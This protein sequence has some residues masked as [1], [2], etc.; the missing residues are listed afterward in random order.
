M[1]RKLIIFS[2]FLFAFCF[3]GCK[4]T[5]EKD[6]TFSLS[7]HWIGIGETTTIQLKK[8]DSL[9]DFS[10]KA[11]PSNYV[12]IGPTGEIVALKK[13]TVQIQ[14]TLKSD[15]TKFYTQ[16]LEISN[17]LPILNLPS[18]LVKGQMEELSIS[19]LE[20][21]PELS[22][23]DFTITISNS[24]LNYL[25]SGYIV[26]QEEGTSVI[27][28]TDKYNENR[29]V[30]KEVTIVENTTTSVLPTLDLR[31][32][33]LSVQDITFLSVENYPNLNLFDIFV[34]KEDVIEIDSYYRIRGMNVGK[35]TIYARLKTDHTCVG[36]IDLEI[37]PPL[38]QVYVSKDK[39]AVGDISYYNILNLTETQADSL[40]DFV[41]SVDNDHIEL[42]ENY[43]LKGV[44]IGKSKLIATSKTNPFITNSYTIEI[45]DS[46]TSVVVYP[47]DEY[48]GKI[49]TGDQVR[50][51]LSGNFKI[52]D[53]RFSTTNSEILRVNEEGLVTTLN[54]GVAYVTI[55]EIAN[56]S[57]NTSFAFTVEGT[58]DIDYVKRLLDLAIHEKGYVERYD[59]VSGQYVNDTKYNHWYNMDGPWC[60]MFV[61]WCWY[62]AGLSNE[63]LLKYASVYLGQQWCIQQGIFQYKEKYRPKSGD[64]IFFLSSGSSH[65]GIVV[66]SDENYV[67]TIE[68]NASNRVDVWRWSI[69]DARITG[70]GTPNYPSYS[71]T[72]ADFSWIAGKMNNGEYWWNNVPEKQEMT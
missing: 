26:A 47:N 37:I 36:S 31:K 48:T 17:I 67:Y 18:T 71:S 46:A 52:S 9:E 3:I 64:I 14:V 11:E 30:T 58:P 35:V 54:E 39:I 16:I 56:P 10:I 7:N 65:T 24:H 19:N 68:G 38:P 15:Q 72:P 29:Y 70:Y 34:S 45:V 8:N 22:M 51:S 49:H 44:S 20:E 32:S 27:R 61:S 55:S 62:Q 23:E 21:I 63:L 6:P 13:G 25:E 42:L 60:A 40:D 28:L 41:W 2:L 43:C 50:L 59:P 5:D 12:S 69:R 1:K 66:Y 57:N 33:I 4:K 53:F